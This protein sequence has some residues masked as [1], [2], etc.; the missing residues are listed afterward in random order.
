MEISGGGKCTMRRALFWSGMVAVAL[1]A[2]ASAQTNANSKPAT[3]NIARGKY[4]V[5]NV[6]KCGDC[7]TP[8]DKQGNPIK[9]KQ[10]Q[11]SPLVFTPTV[12]I[13]AWVPV[14]PGIAGLTWTDEQA[15]EFFT[16]GKRPDGSMAGP[17]MPQLRLNKADAAAVTAYLKSLK[18]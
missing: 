10:L 9:S 12:P 11:G 6:A 7:H 15:I 3:G 4:L 2:G 5:N 14:A 8:M 18:P 16:T 1:A 17:P 13:P